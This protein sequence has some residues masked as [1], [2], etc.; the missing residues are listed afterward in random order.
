MAQKSNYCD[1]CH[2]YRYAN[3]TSGVRCCHYLLWTNRKRPCDPGDACTV[4]VPVKAN[5]RKPP[6]IRRVV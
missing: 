1:N 3:G 4:K 5:R 2:Y 6:T